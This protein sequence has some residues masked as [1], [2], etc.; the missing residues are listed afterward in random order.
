VGK[1]LHQEQIGK[2]NERKRKAVH[3]QAH[4]RA[5]TLIAEER[6]KPKKN[7]QTTAQVIAQVEVEFRARGYDV[8]LSKNTINRYVA[9]GMLG[10]FPLVRGYKGMMPKHAFELLVLAVESF[11]QISN[12]KSIDATRS[13]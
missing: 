6:M 4:A 7:H 13:T 3:A 12:V 8:T 10:M 2:Q 9:L 1:T 5:T 11:V